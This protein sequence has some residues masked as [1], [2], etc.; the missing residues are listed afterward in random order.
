MV[1]IEQIHHW[2]HERPFSVVQLKGEV[3]FA[4][5]VTVAA[6]LAAKTS[7]A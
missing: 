3:H 6:P 1:P 7:T 4:P 5:T 2:P